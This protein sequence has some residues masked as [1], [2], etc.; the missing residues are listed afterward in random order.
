MLSNK[1]ARYSKKKIHRI[2]R[3]KLSITNFSVTE[4]HITKTNYDKENITDDIE[5]VCVLEQ[6]AKFGSQIKLY[7]T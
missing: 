5:S 3:D 6:E 4:S 2:K 7:T 1:L